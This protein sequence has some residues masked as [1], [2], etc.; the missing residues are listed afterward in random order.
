MGIQLH[1][2]IPCL[3]FAAEA[4]PEGQGNQAKV[5]PEGLCA[6]IEESIAELAAWGDRE[7]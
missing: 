5:E 1:F 6:D 2:L 4:D 3:P 7:K